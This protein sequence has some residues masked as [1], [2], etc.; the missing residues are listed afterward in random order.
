MST[1]FGFQVTDNIS[2]HF[3]TLYEKYRIKFY[4]GI[5][6]VLG[7]SDAGRNP[8]CLMMSYTRVNIYISLV[9]GTQIL[10]KINNFSYLGGG[11]I[12]SK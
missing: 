6:P 5:L 4:L 3:S 11:Y 2:I 7:E 8:F 10:A 12:F 1:F 9:T